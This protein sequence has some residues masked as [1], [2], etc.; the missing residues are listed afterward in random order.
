MRCHWNAMPRFADERHHQ[1]QQQQNRY[2]GVWLSWNEHRINEILLRNIVV[3]SSNGLMKEVAKR[4]ERES[5]SLPSSTSLWS[6]HPFAGNSSFWLLLSMYL[7]PS[8]T[9]SF[10]HIPC[11][12]PS[13]VRICNGSLVLVKYYTQLQHFAIYI[14]IRPF[15]RLIFR[16]LLGL[17]C[18]TIIIG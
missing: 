8:H 10:L 6:I 11:F 12:S 5:S 17:C 3:R 15:H 9:P 4:R 13:E 1:Q 14:S 2:N 7:S 16:I 18:A